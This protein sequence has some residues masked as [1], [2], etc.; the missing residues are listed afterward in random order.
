MPD[1]QSLPLSKLQ[2]WEVLEMIDSYGRTIDYLRLSVT[3]QCNLRCRYCMP[4]NFACRGEAERMTE[5]ELIQAVEAAAFL[6]I[7]KVR[8]TGGEPLVRPDIVSICQNIAAVPGIEEVCITTNGTLLAPQAD[9]LRK[10]GVSRVNLSLD[11]LQAEKYRTM[12]RRDMHHRAMEGFHAALQAGFEKVK[13]N[14]VLLGGWNEDETADLAALT[15]KYAV[16]VRFI[17]W[18]PMYD[19]GEFG[20]QTMIPCQKVLEYLPD[21]ESLEQRDGVARLYRLPHAKGNIGLISPVSSHF[22]AF[23]NRLRLTADGKLKPCLHAP[24]EISILGCT[25]QE[26]T[27]RMRQAIEAKPLQHPPLSPVSRSRSGRTMNEIGG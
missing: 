12:T 16:D 26:M 8:V 20:D 11:T 22:C 13:I 3:D 24:E 21:A 25:V 23:C 4:E 15:Q 9:A 17:E 19:S 6:G 27:V 14:T 18:M 7:R 1:V 10:A 5:A 2:F